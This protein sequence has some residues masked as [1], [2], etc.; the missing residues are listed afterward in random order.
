[1]GERGP[2]LKVSPQVLRLWH[3]HIF[4]HYNY[5]LLHAIKTGTVPCEAEKEFAFPCFDILMV[6]S[7]KAYSKPCQKALLACD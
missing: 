3:V 7:L 2:S 6:Y 5:R 1:M 4:A